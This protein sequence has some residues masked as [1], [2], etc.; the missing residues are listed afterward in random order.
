MRKKTAQKNH[1]IFSLFL[2]EE[3]LPQDFFALLDL[4]AVH[5]AQ[6]NLSDVAVVFD[7][8]AKKIA[9]KVRAVLDEKNVRVPV[10]RLSKRVREEIRLKRFVFVLLPKKFAG[11]SIARARRQIESR[12]N[13]LVNLIFVTT[14]PIKKAKDFPSFTFFFKNAKFSRF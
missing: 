10:I 12:K 9:E 8:R 2:L 13:L 3:N 7:S 5:S 1:R 14:R 6:D 4:L 11:A